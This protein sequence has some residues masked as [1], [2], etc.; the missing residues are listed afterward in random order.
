MSVV[1]SLQ[2]EGEERSDAKSVGLARMICEYRFVCI[3]LLMCDTLPVIS[4][5]SRCFQYDQCDY[6]IIPSM[7]PS[8]LTSLEQLTVS[9]GFNLQNL[10][11]FLE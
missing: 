10:P 7:L 2:R 11:A 4:H 9:G 1:L 8:T 6:S 3:V 5:L